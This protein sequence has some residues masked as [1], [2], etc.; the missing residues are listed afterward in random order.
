MLEHKD[1]SKYVPQGMET[2]EYQCRII[3][4]VINDFTKGY[5]SILIESPTGS[6]KSL[7]GLVALK[8]M[9]KLN[10][11]V[12]INWVAMRRK[13]LSQAENENKKVGVT[14]IQYVSMFDK[15]PPKAD[16]LCIDEGHHSA[17]ATM[18]S[19]IEI[20]GAKKILSLT[21]T[22]FRS[23]RVRLSF[24]RIVSDCGVRFL[25]EQN[26]LSQ[27]DSYIIPKYI[28]EE[29]A[30][31]LLINPEHWGKSV[32]FFRTAE[33]CFELESLLLNGGVFGAVMLGSDSMEKRNRM[34]DDFDNGDIQVLINMQLLI[35]GF[36]CCDLRSVFVRDS[37]KLVT[38][39][40]AGRSLR[41]DPN[42]KAKIANII[43]SSNTYWPYQKCVK[44]RA[45]KQYLW[46]D[47]KWQ[48]LEASDRAFRVMR[49]TRQNIMA[50]PAKLPQYLTD[51]TQQIST[52]RVTAKGKIVTANR[53]NAKE[54]DVDFFGDNERFQNGNS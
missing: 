39:Q 21:A 18:A 20:I 42:N 41:K 6:G 51:K 50:N 26:Y 29:I 43:Q 16:I 40:M 54:P 14:D 15:N 22:P 12:K 48:A 3:A 52:I 11:G 46:K 32:C 10:P 44:I 30:K 31:Q 27:F 37:N 24:E 4:S 34:F 35:E 17:A 8:I 13:L 53:S 7:M 45:R 1:I 47:E 28:P 33:E 5:K 49:K 9:Q 2:R 36:D 23:D 19:L 38:L 25:I